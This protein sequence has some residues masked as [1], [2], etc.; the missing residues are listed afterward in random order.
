MTIPQDLMSSRAHNSP[1]Q[2]WFISDIRLD[3]GKV[4]LRLKLVIRHRVSLKH[5]VQ[6]LVLS[7]YDVHYVFN[8]LENI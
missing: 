8:L 1:I 7:V 4:S 3:K 6:L 5:L 2:F